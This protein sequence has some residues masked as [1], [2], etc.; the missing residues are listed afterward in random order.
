M[1]KGKIEVDKKVEKNNTTKK[2]EPKQITMAAYLDLTIAKGGTW[3]ELCKKA[4]TECDKRGWKTHYTAGTFNGHIK[5]RVS[6]DKDWLKARKLKV[7][8]DGIT[9]K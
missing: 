3:P 7:T 4:Q 8:K 5:Y 1:V 9:V 6:Q 2:V